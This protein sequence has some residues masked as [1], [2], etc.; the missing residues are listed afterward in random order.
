MDA[1]RIG[2]ARREYARRN[3]KSFTQKDAAEHFGVS[4]G[5]YR[6]WEQGRVGLNSGQLDAISDLYGVTV[7]YLLGRDAPA[8]APSPQP[9][10]PEERELLAL[11]R[12][13]NAHGREQLMVFARGCAASWPLN[14]AHSLGA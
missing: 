9:M 3:K 10:T 5:T 6:N 4:L 1:S 11:Y 12:A 2:D 8:A 14:Q 13:T 7:D